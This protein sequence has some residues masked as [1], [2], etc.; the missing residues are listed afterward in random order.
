M[1]E[2]K[3]DEFITIWCETFFQRFWVVRIIK[4]SYFLTEL[5]KNN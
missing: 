5:L 3:V 1:A 4:I 2:G